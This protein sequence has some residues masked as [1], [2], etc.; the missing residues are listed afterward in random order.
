MLEEKLSL[1]GMKI[2]IT[3]GGTGLGLE[4]TTALARAG[5]DLVIASRRQGPIDEAAQIVRDLGRKAIAV[6]TDVTD[7]TQVNALMERALDEFGV[8]DVLINNAG[9]VR[10]QGA[11]SIWEI[12]DEEW[13]LGIDT[14]MSSAFYCSRAIAQHMV[15]RGLGK[16]INVSSILGSVALPNQLAYCA[17]KGGVEQMTKVMALEWAKQGVRVNAIAP[18]YF[19]TELVAQLRNDPER[20]AF[21]NERT[22][23][24][25][26]GQ[27][28]E[29]EGLVVFLAASGSDFITGQSILIDGGWTIW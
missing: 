25:R 1:E 15:E 13:H 3:G 17:S 11:T 4:M 23:M 9:I 24:G 29:L 6:S 8:V 2:V 28:E 26:W 14:N 20:V 19:E 10:G 7:S 16:I 22:P 21:I 27:P 18:T 12:S 5:A